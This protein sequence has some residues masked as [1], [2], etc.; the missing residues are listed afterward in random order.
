MLIEEILINNNSLGFMFRIENGYLR[1]S[2][3]FSSTQ[4]NKFD[5]IL[6]KLF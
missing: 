2:T 4:Q 3:V 5:D 6:K 1:Y